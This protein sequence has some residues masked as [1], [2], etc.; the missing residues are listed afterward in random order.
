MVLKAGP[1]IQKLHHHE[2][3]EEDEEKNQIPQCQ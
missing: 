3:S 1:K 2:A